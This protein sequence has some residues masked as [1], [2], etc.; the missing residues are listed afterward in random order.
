MS[1]FNA[2]FGFPFELSHEQLCNWSLKCMWQWHH[3][4]VF[5]VFI[6]DGNKTYRLHQYFVFYVCFKLD[7]DFGI[8]GITFL[9]MVCVWFFF[10]LHFLCT[11]HYIQFVSMLFNLC[12]MWMPKCCRYSISISIAIAFYGN[13]WTERE[14]IPR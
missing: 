14:Q 6:V 5:S 3:L 11:I 13:G 10:R 2:L 4:N 7:C 9:F 12:L 1:D 8:V